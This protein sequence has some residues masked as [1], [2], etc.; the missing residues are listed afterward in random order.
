[1]PYTVA[2]LTTFFTN[3]NVGR[4]PTAADTVFLNALATQNQ[5]GALTDA[6]VLQ[7]VV[8]SADNDTAVALLTY[9]FFTG[10]TPTY[11][12]LQYLVNSAANPNDLGDAYYSQFNLENRFI[13]FAANLALGGPDSAAFAATYGNLSVAQTIDLAF[14]TII[15]SGNAVAAGLNPAASKANIGSAERIAYFQALVNQNFAGASAATKDL[16]LKAEII[17]YIMAEAVKANVGT[18]AQASSALLQDLA[19]DNQA[20]F[21]TDITVSYG[22]T[23]GTI[24]T[25]TANPD[26]L[27]ANVFNAPRVFSPGG[28]EQLN[29]LNDDDTLTGTGTN[30]TLNLTFVD[31]TDGFDGSITPTLV[32]IETINVNYRIDADAILDLQDATGLLNLNLEGIEDGSDVLVDNITPGADAATDGFN[33]SISNT[34]APASDVLVLFDDE[35][36]DA[37]RTAGVGGDTVNI[38]LEDVE[39]DD[40]V[41]EA[42]DGED[43]G[44]EV[45]NVTSNG[46]E[47]EVGT[48]ELE[49]AQEIYIDGEGDLSLGDELLVVGP[50]D[51][52]EAEYRSSSFADVDGSLRLIDAE[53][54]TGDLD[55]TLGTYLNAILEGTSGDPVNFV[56]I[57]GAG[58]DTVRLP[59]GVLIELQDSLNGGGGTNTLY[60]EGNTSVLAGAGDIDI[61]NFQN[62]DVRTGHD[63]GTGGDAVFVDGSR[64]TSLAT[65]N[66]RNEGSTGGASADEG[67]VVTLTNLGA[68]AN[69]ITVQHS[70]S[71][72]NGIDDTTVIVSGTGS[73]TLGV[74]IATERNTDPRFNFTLQDATATAI[75]LRDQDNESNSVRNLGATAVTLTL[76]GGQVGRFL[77]LDTGDSDSTGFGTEADRVGLYLTDVSG[78]DVA[79]VGDD[80]AVRA[81]ADIDEDI[82]GL[83]PSTER[84]TGTI[85]A[86]TFAG[87]IVVRV[88][89]ANQSITLGTGNDTL[90]FDAIG[91]LRAGLSISDTVDGGTGNDVLVIDG[92]TDDVVG[93]QSISVGASEWTN[94]RNF[95]TIRLVGNDSGLSNAGAYGDNGYNLR[96]TNELI[97]QNGEAA[98]TNRRINIINDNG[99]TAADEVGAT[100]DA[101][102]LSSTNSFTYNGEEGTGAGGEGD[103]TRD[104]FIMADANINGVAVIDGGTWGGGVA[105]LD[106]LEVRNSAVVTI[107]DLVG[108]S[109]VGTI[110]FTNDTAATQQSLLQLD[111]ATIARMAS[112]DQLTVRVSGNPNVAGAT[113]ELT[114]EDT[115]VT[116]GSYVVEVTGST[117]VSVVSQSGVGG[118]IVGNAD[119][120]V[121]NGGLAA[122][123][124]NGGAGNDVITGAGGADT[125][126]G[127]TGQ[128]TVSGNAGADRFFIDAE[129]GDASNLVAGATDVITDFVSGVDVIDVNGSDALADA[130]SVGN[131]GEA[132]VADF[133][134]GQAAADAFFDGATTAFFLAEVAGGSYLFIDENVGSAPDNV[135]FLAGVTAATFNF[136][137]IV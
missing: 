69:A 39:I 7:A 37:T 114:I 94:V 56:L 21:N 111:N 46:D 62:L 61:V 52:T 71:G 2:E 106:V 1:M 68:A 63:V 97:A 67:A 36:I 119:N 132:V 109:N 108:V 82:V 129:N 83:A 41:V 18:Y 110:E 92:D 9:Q 89:T 49:D 23:G 45:V 43:E 113:T 72:S 120:N 80:T 19:T 12:G 105:N 116:P 104:R 33:L 65:V 29:S 40:L 20:I 136:T 137:D 4:G 103:S 25:L 15:G 16:A 126:A 124:I 64:I 44:F 66:V 30:P 50:Q 133:A 128:D 78:D 95:E 107:G 48:V 6:Q 100:I 27:T 75:N 93:P 131:Y 115:G 35:A 28:D 118:G 38:A 127:G 26:N 47:N 96:L 117:A 84:Y 74:T 122:D 130:G 99:T 60:V 87:D 17:G 14:E 10:E 11:A 3:V 81:I 101:R 32:N 53:E 59:P 5:A 57:G 125:V 112:G 55:I 88:G 90:I 123:S 42:T 91:D 135:V 121:I 31:E 8:D 98:G 85:A 102:F 34:N 54:L 134:A 13:N 73:G 79:F 24:A 51:Q 58:N 86:G 76:T 70:T 22:S 77:N